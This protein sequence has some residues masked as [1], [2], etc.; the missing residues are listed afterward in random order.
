VTVAPNGSLTNLRID[1]SAWRGSGAELAG[2]IMH[3]ARK[4]QRS[5]AVNVAEAFAPLGAGSEALHMVTGYIP[6]PEEDEEEDRPGY[7]FNAEPEQAPPPPPGPA[8]DRDRT[9]PPPG[10]PA[11]RTLATL[12]EAVGDAEA[13]VVDALDEAVVAHAEP[14][15]ARFGSLDI[16]LNVVSG[17][18]VQ[19]LPLTDI[20]VEDSSR[21]SPRACGPTFITARTAARLMAAQGSGAVMALNSGSGHAGRAR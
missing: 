8:A 1:E 2:R 14:V 13:A 6:E 18:D 10:P 9:T 7:A 19:G 15:V 5:A 20:A 4:A 12:T 17:G 16:S 21:R 3:L 11:G